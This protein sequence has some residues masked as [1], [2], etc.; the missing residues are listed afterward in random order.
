MSYFTIWGSSQRDKSLIPKTCCNFANTVGMDLYVQN[1][2]VDVRLDNANC[3]DMVLDATRITLSSPS[4]WSVTIR[5][6]FLHSSS[7]KKLLII[8]TGGEQCTNRSIIFGCPDDLAIVSCSLSE[9][10]T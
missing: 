3:W 7:D 1:H 6:T 4:T 9:V 2:E 5:C 8:N 10:V